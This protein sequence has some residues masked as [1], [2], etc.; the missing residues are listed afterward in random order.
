[1]SRLVVV[2]N[3]IADPRKAAA[4]GLAVAVKDSLQ[5]TGGVWFGWSG[6]LRGADENG[7]GRGGEVQIQNVGGIQLATID[8][9][10]QDYDAYYLGYS[11]NVL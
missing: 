11:N 6:R 7:P 5:E 8:L 9:D 4:G 3:R 10:P 2:S 1:M